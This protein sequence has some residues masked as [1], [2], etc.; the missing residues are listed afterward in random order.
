MD[1]VIAPSAQLY[2]LTASR[3]DKALEG[4]TDD[5]ARKRLTDDS[6]PVIWIVGHM[7]TTR[8]NLLAML[9]RPVEHPWGDQFGRGSKVGDGT[10]FPPL[11]DLVIKW[12]EA[13]EA[14]KQRLEEL[15][16][17]ELSA[18]APRDFPIEDKTLRG[19]INFL[20]FHDV[21][22]F[23]QMALLKKCLGQGSLVG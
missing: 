11:A 12:R 9:G 15:T 22:H 16:G 23:G 21:Y 20:A 10:E 14:L 7:T 6:N 13:D 17:E 8:C 2:A 18:A 1:P 5:D 19:A 4:L 3:F